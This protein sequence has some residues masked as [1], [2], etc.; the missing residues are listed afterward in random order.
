MNYPEVEVKT[1]LRGS[2][3]VLTNSSSLK[4]DFLLSLFSA[5]RFL[6]ALFTSDLRP[7]TSDILIPPSESPPSD[8][9]LRERSDLRLPI[10]PFSAQRFHF[11]PFGIRPP[12]YFHP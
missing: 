4:F 11:P 7:P 6:L 1:A 2:M 5:Q 10:P 9:E 3:A 12:V 8:S